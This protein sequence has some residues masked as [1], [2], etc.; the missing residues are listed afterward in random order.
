MMFCFFVFFFFFVASC[1]SIAG[2]GDNYGSLSWVIGA[3]SLGEINA[4]EILQGIP[5]SIGCL[6]LRVIPDL[7]STRD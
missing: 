7:H 2:Q 3:A 5:I 4:G 1:I 6:F